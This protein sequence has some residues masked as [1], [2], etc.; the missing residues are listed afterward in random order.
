ME[1]REAGPS[2]T[3]VITIPDGALR[4]KPFLWSLILASDVFTCLKVIA[5]VSKDTWAGAKT[6]RVLRAATRLMLAQ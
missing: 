5:L 1:N 3:V 6:V 2:R 4:G